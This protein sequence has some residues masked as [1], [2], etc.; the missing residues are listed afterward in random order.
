MKEIIINEDKVTEEE[1]NQ[2]VKRSKLVVENSKGELLVVKCHGNCY[3]IGGH[4]DGDEEDN[5][6]LVREIKEEAG[7]DYDPQVT[8]PF[9][10]ILYYCRDYPVRG[11]NTKYI[12]NYYDVK[13]DLEPDPS[14][15]NL[16]ED[17]AAGG[18]RLV[19]V[20]KNKILA[21]LDGILETCVRKNVVRDTMAVIEEYLK[22]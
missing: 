7:I 5:A 13:Y 17:E 21:E 4:V 6:T 2:I 10:R 18:F 8:E 16:T 19:Y 22:K 11:I 9:Y 15:V 3:L 12:S 14:N 1:V 20:P